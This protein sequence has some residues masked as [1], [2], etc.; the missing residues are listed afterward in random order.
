MRE[1]HHGRRAV[2]LAAV[3]MLTA[4]AGAGPVGAATPGMHTPGIPT[5]PRVVGAPSDPPG[6]GRPPD[7]PLDGPGT[8]SWDTTLDATGAIRGHT[9]R[10][11]T[12]GTW[13]AGPRAFVDGPFRDIL[14][15]G[16]R[17]AR[18]TR[19][20]LI[21]LVRGCTVRA[22]TVRSLVYGSV[23][24][25]QGILIVSLVDPRT[26]AE[27]GVWQVGAGRSP[28]LR[29]IIL[30]P[31]GVQATAVPR[32]STLRVSPLGIQARWCAGGSCVARAHSTAPVGL[33]ALVDL[34]PEAQLDGSASLPLRYRPVPIYDR[35]FPWS[36]LAFRYHTTEVSPSWMRE[37]IEAAADDA[38]DTS[39]AL[40]PIFTP[41]AS[42]SQ[43]VIR[44][45]A[46]FPASCLNAIA[47][48][49]HEADQWTLRMRPQGY[50]F[51]WGTLRWC[52]RT[53]SDGCFDAERVAL[54]EF[55]HVVGLDHPET[56]GFRLSPSS[57]VM[58]Q[59]TASRPHAAWDRHSFGACDVA[60]LQEQFGTPTMSTLISGCNDVDT[61]TTLTASATQV[62]AGGRLVLTATLRIRSDSA[63]GQ[64]SGMRLDGRSVQ[65][66]RRPVGST[67]TWTTSWMRA[68]GAPGVY[69]ITLYPRATYEYKAAFGTPDNEGL[70]GDSSDALTVQVTGGCAGNCPSEEGPA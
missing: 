58:H 51:R 41:G 68:S 69:S 63:Y 53:N 17:S 19:L 31:T 60:S 33:A 21:D 34:D 24:T 52:Q 39:K 23:L 61:L 5:C 1:I 15:A 7:R 22:L 62:G 65:L 25:D 28:R 43:G 29:R 14:I 38:T 44:Y 45:T 50:D 70:H 12:T 2:V 6:S 32:E 4:G 59:V 57:T 3:A 20:R 16:Q 8:F 55:G 49:G 46:S 18:S 30:P 11:G 36:A 40:S 10:L 35:W 9:L 37:A 64:L 48:A 66:R 26:R 42:G 67:D 27:L 13:Q 56:V 54:H 47:C